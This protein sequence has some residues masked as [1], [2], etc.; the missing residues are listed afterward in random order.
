M[1]LVHHTLWH[2]PK[3]E[4]YPAHQSYNKRY[5]Q[6]VRAIHTATMADIAFGKYYPGTLFNEFGIDLPV[7]F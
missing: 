4:T 5:I 7:P 1:V 2:N 6:T 3:D